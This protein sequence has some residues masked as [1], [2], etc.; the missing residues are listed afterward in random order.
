MEPHQRRVA[1]REDSS[2]MPGA[3]EVRLVQEFSRLVL[4]G[5]T[6]RSWPEWTLSTQRVLDACWKSA[7]GDGIEIEVA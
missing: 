4:S 6:D 5:Q 7:A 1:V 3:Q 2:A